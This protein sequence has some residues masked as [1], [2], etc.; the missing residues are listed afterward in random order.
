MLTVGSIPL[1][2]HCY[3]VGFKVMNSSY[4]CISIPIEIYERYGGTRIDNGNLSSTTSCGYNFQVD[5][6]NDCPPTPDEECEVSCYRISLNPGTEY[7]I[8]FK[9][10]T[11][12][13]SLC[14][15]RDV[16]ECEGGI[17]DTYYEVT[18]TSVSLAPGS[19]SC[20]EEHLSGYPDCSVITPLSVS[21][22]IYN[23]VFIGDKIVFY[24]R[25]TATGGD[26]NY[27]FSWSG[28]S[29]TSPTSSTN[30]NTA[31]RTILKS[32][33]ATVTVTVTSDGQTVS[34]SKTLSGERAM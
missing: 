13:K 34:K 7:V 30:P 21:L 10:P 4:N 29:R 14:F 31:K 2:S 32:Q 26:Q 22:V 27:I 28:A 8:V 9:Y 3:E 19:D 25:A 24:L 16:F 18:P 11:G 1:F 17:F 12:D 33:T 6:D 20:Y 15:L 5:L 23:T